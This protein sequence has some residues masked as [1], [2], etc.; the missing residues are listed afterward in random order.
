M[1]MS[2]IQK[3]VCK[4]L[5]AKT[6]KKKVVYPTKK[7]SKRILKPENNSDLIIF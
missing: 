6:V 1:A 4:N 3:R 7:E 2:L 5:D